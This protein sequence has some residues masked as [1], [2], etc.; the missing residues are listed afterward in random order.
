MASF[1]TLKAR[2]SHLGAALSSRPKDYNPKRSEPFNPDTMKGSVFFHYSASFDCEAVVAKYELTDRVAHPD[3]VTN[4]LGVRIDTS[5]WPE[6]LSTVKGQVESVPHPA[7]WH[8]DLIEWASALRAVDEAG[9]KFTMIELGCGW[10]CWINNLGVAAKRSGREIEVIG[11]EGSAHHLDNAKRILEMNSIKEGE[12][13]LVH[14]IAAPET[15]RALFPKTGAGAYGSEP[16]FFPDDATYAALMASGNYDE[17]R[18]VTL[19]QLSDG[20]TVDLLH[21][22]IQGGEFDYVTGN[23]D[24]LCQFVKRIF[25][26][27]HGRVIEGKLVEHFLAERW[28]LEAERPSVELVENGTMHL[29]VDG[30]QLWLNPAKA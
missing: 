2:A 3:Y 1:N 14:G 26:G 8:A 6:F 16:V 30:A 4:F 12:A 27:T 9:P 21:V 29:R 10:G 19:D 17:L 23:W 18:T 5:P 20:Q 28:M 24:Q 13:K 22:D 15:G 25:I 11:V 7:N